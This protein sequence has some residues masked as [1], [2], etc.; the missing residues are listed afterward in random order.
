[1]PK[2]KN[3][4]Q[5]RRGAGFVRLRNILRPV[6]PIRATSTWK[7]AR[8]CPPVLYRQAEAGSIPPAAWSGSGAS[9]PNRMRQRQR[10]NRRRFSRLARLGLRRGGGPSSL[11]CSLKAPMAGKGFTVKKDWDNPSTTPCP[12]KRGYRRRC[13]SVRFSSPLPPCWR[14]WLGHGYGL[15]PL[16]PPRPAC[17]PPAVGQTRLRRRRAMPEMRLP[18]RPPSPT[19]SPAAA[20]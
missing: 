14:R 2:E 6:R 18:S 20:C 19:P 11:R 8:L 4:S 5:L 7:S 16:H 12:P 3:P 1:M 17:S 13:V 15:P 10:S 9:T